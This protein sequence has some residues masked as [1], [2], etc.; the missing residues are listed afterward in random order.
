VKIN[1][2]FSTDYFA[3]NDVFTISFVETTEDKLLSLDTSKL[4]VTTDSGEAVEAI[5]GWSKKVSLTKNLIVEGAFVLVLA[6]PPEQP[7][8]LL[9]EIERLTQE[10][11]TLS[12]EV[13]VAKADV[14]I[15]VASLEL[16][17]NDSVKLAAGNYASTRTLAGAVGAA[18]VL[19]PVRNWEKGMT[20]APGE[21][22][23]DPDEEFKY[24]YAG[25]D[26][27]THANQLFFPGA[28]GVYYWAIVPHMLNGIK[29]YPAVTGIIVSVRKDE[30]WYDPK[31]EK[32][33]R[34]NAADWTDCSYPAGS[35][36]VH[37]WVEV[38]DAI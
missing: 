26:V 5:E 4:V 27:M 11:G 33:Y 24:M 8:E 1:N 10:N 12:E 14:E 38:E 31:G 32:L 6:Q 17:L 20:T 7:T 9:E 34:W 30:L 16:L 19:L 13:S 29:V 15:G 36:G 25:K 22:V 2:I 28:S 35:A 23:Y 21:F 3:Q 37:Q 18:Q